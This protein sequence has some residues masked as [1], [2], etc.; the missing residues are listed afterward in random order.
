ML[1]NQVRIKTKEVKKKNK[2]GKRKSRKTFK[3]SLRFLGVNS[4]GLG[5]KVLTFK[6]VIQELSPSV[7]FVEET[8]LKEAGK[9]KLDIK[10]MEKIIPELE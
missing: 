10:R 6:K 2:R 1:R 3:K 5:S 4:A 7:F 9:I 8:K